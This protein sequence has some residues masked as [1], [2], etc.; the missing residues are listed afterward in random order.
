MG[1]EGPGNAADDL[2]KHVEA[3]FRRSEIALESKDEGDGRI[4][5]PTGNRPQDCNKHH[6]NRASRQRVAQKREPRIPRQRLGHDARPNDGRDQKSRSKRFSREPSGK[7]SAHDVA[8]SRRPMSRSFA[9]RAILSRL[10]IG[11][12]MK[13]DIRF[14]KYL[15]AVTKA[16]SFSMLPVP[17]NRTLNG[18]S[19]IAVL[20][21]TS[22]REI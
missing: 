14:F 19:L 12:L 15:N 10:R 17:R 11:R 2:R 21:L 16:R 3:R 8:P 9:P 4:E 6:E 22:G 7:R 5:M 1:R 20:L 13:T 18:R